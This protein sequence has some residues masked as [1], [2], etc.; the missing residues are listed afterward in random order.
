[1]IHLAERSIDGLRAWIAGDP[2]PVLLD[3]G[4]STQ[5]HGTDISGPLW[6]ARAIMQEPERVRQAHMQFL[7]AGAEILITGSYQI[8]REGFLR[9]GYQAIQAEEALRTSVRLAREAIAEAMECATPS[10]IPGQ[11]HSQRRT[12]LVAASIGPYGAILHDGSEYRGGYDLSP[13]QLRSFHLQR[14]EILAEA[15]PDLLVCETI[16]DLREVEVLLAAL[17]EF[18]HL[19]TTVSCTVRD[20][21]Y[22]SGGQPIEALAEVVSPQVIALGVNC[23]APE[24]V[25]ALLQRLREHTALPLVAYPNA[26]G[27]WDAPSEQWITGSGT[28][29]QGSFGVAQLADLTSP[30]VDLI[31]GCCGTD[32]GDIAD[33]RR[34]LRPRSAGQTTH[35]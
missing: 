1:M 35:S 26:G 16:P 12:P 10:A 32:A 21:R 22:V 20:D 29:L 19:A 34:S 17:T 8:S 33:L 14:I 5:L 13:G 27:T 6:T 2:H 4:L 28:A 30:P 31:G 23:C 9:A 15:Q 24:L 25:P 7:Q 18:A 11:R 3:G